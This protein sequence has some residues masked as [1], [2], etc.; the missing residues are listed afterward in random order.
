MAVLSCVR[1]AGQPGLLTVVGRRVQISMSILACAW[2]IVLS[3]NAATVSAVAP[4]PS[5]IVTV[6]GVPSV[7]P[8]GA[9]RRGS[10]DI[11]LENAGGA[12]SEEGVV[13]HDLLPP[14]LTAINA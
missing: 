9:G 4:Q 13:V 12:P 8:L 1:Q 7:L 6:D 10:F 3:C 14:G 2:L 11:V 5:W